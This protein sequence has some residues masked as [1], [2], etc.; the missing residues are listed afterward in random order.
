MK[1][2]N[3]SILWRIFFL[4]IANSWDYVHNFCNRPFI[5]FYQHCREWY[6]Y[7]LRKNNTEMDYDNDFNKNIFLDEAHFGDDDNDNFPV[8]E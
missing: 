5:S 8:N 3:L 6:F 2:T 1:C 7:N 4:K